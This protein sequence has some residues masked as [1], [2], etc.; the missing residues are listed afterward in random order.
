MTVFINVAVAG[1]V[2][3]GLRQGLGQPELFQSGASLRLL[4][5]GFRELI[6][7]KHL[8]GLHVSHHPGTHGAAHFLSLDHKNAVPVD[9]SVLQAPEPGKYLHRLSPQQG[10]VQLPAQPRQNPVSAAQPF[11]VRA[12]LAQH[13]G[14]LR[15]R[16]LEHPQQGG[17]PTA[18]PGVRLSRADGEGLGIVPVVH[19]RYASFFGRGF[20]LWLL[21]TNSLLFCSMPWANSLYNAG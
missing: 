5:Q 13:P 10:P 1:N 12:V 20:L 9:Q 8:P 21:G 3:I 16:V 6:R 7:P 15:R 19:G 2:D 11:Q 18:A 4:P 14:G 17:G